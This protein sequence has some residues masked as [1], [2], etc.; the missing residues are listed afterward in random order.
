MDK[1]RG[2]KKRSLLPS[3]LTKNKDYV[4]PSWMFY[5]VLHEFIDANIAKRTMYFFADDSSAVD[6]YR[7][8]LLIFHIFLLL[9]ALTVERYIS[10]C[11]PFLRYSFDIK[12]WYYILS[13]MTFSMVY[14]TP[15][16]FEWMTLSEPI[17]RPCLSALF[18][19]GM[20]E[21]SLS[22]GKNFA[23]PLSEF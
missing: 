11:W 13:V 7:F 19:Q 8:L 21:P 20:C 12:S 10:I 22:F 5:M 14:N 23:D 2:I 16:F 9:Q 17:E 6:T 4:L 15:R 1:K 18:H 3:N